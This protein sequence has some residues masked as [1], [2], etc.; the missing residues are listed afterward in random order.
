MAEGEAATVETLA[1]YRE[2][3][4]SLIK[5]HRGRVVDSLGDNVFDEFS[6]V[7]D[8][9]QRYVAVQSEFQTRNTEQSWLRT[10]EWSFANKKEGKYD[11]E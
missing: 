10:V 9:E 8:T 5:Q 11:N 6:S 3:M 2:I 7:V 1:A 4:A